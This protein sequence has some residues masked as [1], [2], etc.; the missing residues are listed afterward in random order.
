[1]G[2]DNEYDLE[3]VV[4]CRHCLWIGPTV[5]VSWFNGKLDACPCCGGTDFDRTFIEQWEDKF[6]K[7][8]KQGR[9]LNIKYGNKKGVEL[10]KTIMEMPR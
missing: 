8:Y 1:M 7:K 10:W 6:Q 4:Y 9:Y 3:P 2:T 5:E